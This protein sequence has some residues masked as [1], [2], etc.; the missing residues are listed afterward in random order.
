M[1]RFIGLLLLCLMT[2]FSSAQIFKGIVVDDAGNPVP[3]ATLYLRKLNQVSP[4]MSK[5]GFGQTW[6]PEFILAR[7]HL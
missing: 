3:H 7:F 4:P 2:I 1:K 6:Q 5:D